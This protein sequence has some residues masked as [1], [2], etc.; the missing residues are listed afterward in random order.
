MTQELLKATQLS[1]Y[2]RGVRAVD[3]IDFSLEEGRLVGL[4][5]PNGAGKSTVFNLLSG[6]IKPTKGSILINGQDMTGRKADRFARMGVARTFQNI[7]LFKEMTVFENVLFGFH[8]STNRNLW[9]S[10]FGSASYRRKENDIRE[11]AEQLLFTFGLFDTRN[12]LA[13]HLS[14]G[15]Q[16]RLEILRALATKPKILFLDEPAAGMNPYEGQQLVQ[17]IE[18]L[19]KM[20][21]LTVVLIEHDMNVVMRLCQ[22]ILVLD[23]GK[24]IFRGTPEEVRKN[25]QVRTAYLGGDF[26]AGA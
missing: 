9:Q 13:I 21:Q 6:A 20:Y 3:G 16:R 2:F 22:E 14:Y 18:Q 7:R 11:Q 4:I 8:M 1:K 25:K 17:L 15:D 24:L 19:W 23:Y 12:E 5:G 10:L 26:D